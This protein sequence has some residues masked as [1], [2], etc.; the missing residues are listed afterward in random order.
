[1]GEMEE[2]AELKKKKITLAPSMNYVEPITQF[3]P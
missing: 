1:M 3:S 2:K